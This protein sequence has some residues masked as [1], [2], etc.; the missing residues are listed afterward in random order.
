PHCKPC[1]RWN[2]VLI[3]KISLSPQRRDDVLTLS[4]AGDILTINGEAFDFSS[5][6]DGGT[7][8]AGTVPCE[9]I[10]GDVDRVGGDL[11]LTL[12]LPTGPQP[13][14]AVAFPQPIMVTADGPIAVP[15][16]PE[17]EQE[18]VDTKPQQHRN[19][20]AKGRAGHR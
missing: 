4:K 11:Q 13:S 16:D 1:R 5:V 14:Q 8:P 18:H 15:T 19:G 17:P 9:W 10:V 12:I 3:M 20:R 2:L 7:L 6:P